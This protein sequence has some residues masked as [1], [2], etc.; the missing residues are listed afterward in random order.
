LS[1]GCGLGAC[2]SFWASQWQT[3]PQHCLNC[4]PSFCRQAA[5]LVRVSDLGLPVA[6]IGSIL[7]LCFCAQAVDL[8]RVSHIVLLRVICWLDSGPLG[9]P[10][11]SIV[12]FFCVRRP[13]TCCVYLILGHPG[14]LIDSILAIVYVRRLRT[15]CVYLILG[16]PGAT[17]GS[18]V[19]HSFCGFGA[20][21]SF[22][23]PS[24]THSL[25][26]GPLFTC[27]G[28]RLGARISL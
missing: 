11:D 23:V 10:I 12:T 19:A 21:T 1:T 4:D 27:A 5:D 3:L 16:L 22:C 2:I 24:G 26:L 25:N 8:V 18:A 14:A 20:R 7:T 13:R 17:M 28:C 15:W 9:G 6:P